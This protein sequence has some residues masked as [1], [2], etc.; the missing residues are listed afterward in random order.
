MLRGLDVDFDVSTKAALLKQHGFD[1]VSPYINKGWFTTAS[2]QRLRA[3]GLLI[4][5]GFFETTTT[6]SLEGAPAG[7]ADGARALKAMT[8]LGAP[9][10]AAVCFTTDTSATI[11]NMVPIEDYFAGADGILWGHFR[12]SSYADGTEIAELR[13]HGLPLCVLAGAMGWDG[14]RDFAKHGNPNVVQGPPLK[15]GGTW[16]AK[17][18][19]P[20]VEPIA[21]PDLGF[22]YDPEIALTDDFGQWK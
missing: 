1:F 7:V 17:G 8:Q 15:H 22:E 13:K 21:W 3:A 19:I 14:S 10:V 11:K 2:V 12:I 4:G 20:G 9:S 5:P 16:P 18:Q 6:R